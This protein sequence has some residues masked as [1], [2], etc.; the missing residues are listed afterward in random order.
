LIPSSHVNQTSK[1][2]AADQ[3]RHSGV[4]IVFV[5]STTQRSNDSAR[6]EYASEHVGE[7][8]AHRELLPAE[9]TRR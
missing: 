3:Q 8:P 9:E 5:F 2:Y 6:Y 1:K 7:A 4:P